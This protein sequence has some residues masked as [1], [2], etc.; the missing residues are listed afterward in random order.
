MVLLKNGFD[1]NILCTLVAFLVEVGL[2]GDTYAEF[3][4][5]YST[6]I[7]MVFNDRMI[8]ILRTKITCG[9]MKLIL[10]SF[11]RV[12]KVIHYVT[13]AFRANFMLS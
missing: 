1:D 9:T 2:L 8:K 13:A 6:F 5:S 10:N 7:S 11:L 3:N 4:T 12:S